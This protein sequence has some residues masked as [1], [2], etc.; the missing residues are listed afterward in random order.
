MRASVRL[1]GIIGRGASN[2]GEDVVNQVDIHVAIRAGI[3]PADTG[4]ES[5]IEKQVIL[6][7]QVAD[8]RRVVTAGF[9]ADRCPRDAYFKTPP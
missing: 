6:Q 2:I 3:V 1:G 4:A 5:A 8:G 7:Q 9:L